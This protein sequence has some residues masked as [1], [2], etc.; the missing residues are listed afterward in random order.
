MYTCICL[1][2]CHFF[3]SVLNFLSIFTF[4][5]FSFS[6]YLTFDMFGV[7]F[8]SFCFVFIHYSIF[9][10]KNS[11]SSY[12]CLLY[13]TCSCIKKIQK[14]F[15]LL[16]SI[17]DLRNL[18]A[19]FIVYISIFILVLGYFSINKSIDMLG[20][21]VTYQN[22]I[23]CMNEIEVRVLSQV[24]CSIAATFPLN[25]ESLTWHQPEIY[26]NTQYKYR[27]TEEWAYNNNNKNQFRI[28]SVFGHLLQ[29]LFAKYLY[30]CEEE[31]ILHINDNKWRR[32]AWLISVHANSMNF[33]QIDLSSTLNF[34]LF[35]IAH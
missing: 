19:F 7:S 16:S 27:R 5:R 1:F 26:T 14:Y 31:K 10:H 3:C 17:D 34:N 21:N 24:Q 15:F 9:H 29:E 2:S 30:F 13:C 35:W 25:I 23:N 12:A 32:N 11:E 6:V 22:G 33:M 28:F 18:L 8:F 4:I 20:E